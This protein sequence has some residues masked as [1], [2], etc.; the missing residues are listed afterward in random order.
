MGE[1]AWGTGPFARPRRPVRS[2]MYTDTATAQQA[3]GTVQL[4]EK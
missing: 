1:V 4:R 2:P 3:N